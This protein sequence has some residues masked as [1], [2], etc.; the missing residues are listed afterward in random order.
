VRLG[1]HDIV[2]RARAV[3]GAALRRGRTAPGDQSGAAAVE[4]ALVLPILLT[5]LAGIIQC[6]V[7]L[8][9]YLEVTD[10]ASEGARNFAIAR[11][12]SN[13]YTTTTSAVTASAANL[14]SGSITTTLK[15]NGTACTTDTA[16][17]AALTAAPG[18][19]ASVTV[20]YPCLG[21]SGGALSFYTTFIASSGCTLTATVTNRIE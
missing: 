20:T 19:A 5:V 8:N 17:T 11:T 21:A 7:A 3:A 16:C 6:G 18:G 1:L 10:A 9:N 14:T 12:V 13:P 15:V 2:R 4:F